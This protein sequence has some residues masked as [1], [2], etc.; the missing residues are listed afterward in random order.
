MSSRPLPPTSALAL[1]S[2]GL[3]PEEAKGL[4]FAERAVLRAERV[5]A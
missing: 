4:S 3:D 2:A 5:A 1:A